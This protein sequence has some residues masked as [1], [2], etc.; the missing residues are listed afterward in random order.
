MPETLVFQNLL[1]LLILI[2]YASKHYHSHLKNLTKNEKVSC[3]QQ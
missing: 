2:I 3:I 1:L